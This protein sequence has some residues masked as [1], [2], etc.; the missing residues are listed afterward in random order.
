[1]WIRGRK[2]GWFRV[3]AYLCAITVRSCVFLA[4]PQ[5]NTTPPIPAPGL[6]AAPQ[7]SQA[8]VF[9]A[10]D[11]ASFITGASIAVDGGKSAG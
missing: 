3:K 6:L 7:I 4:S 8:I 9:L 1:M 11:K 10:S 2:P 5:T